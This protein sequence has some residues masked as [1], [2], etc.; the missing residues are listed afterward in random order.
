M[1]KLKILK[2]HF[3]Y[4]NYGFDQIW[5]QNRIPEVLKYE[6]N[7]LKVKKYDQLTEKS[8]VS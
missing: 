3:R 4:Q 7:L 2:I 6:I 5:S 1:K 8:T